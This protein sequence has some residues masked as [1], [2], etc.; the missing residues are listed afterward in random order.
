MAPPWG[1]IS[2]SPS[3]PYPVS[4][5]HSFYS[6]ACNEEAVSREMHEGHTHMLVLTQRPLGL[7]IH[8]RLWPE[9]VF[10][11]MAAN[12]FPSLLLPPTLPVNMQHSC[13]QIP[14]FLLIYP[15]I[16]TVDSRTPIFSNGLQVITVLNCIAAQ[17]RPDLAMGMLP[18]WLCILTCPIFLKITPYFVGKGTAC[19]Y[20]YT[21]L[22]PKSDI[23]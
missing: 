7:S 16:I 19:S 9:P 2:S 11:A 13:K 12:G 4:L 21:A 15:L 14:P 18:S 23:F 20:T 6:F 3:K 22:A 17:I 1:Q 5:P 8:P 10:T